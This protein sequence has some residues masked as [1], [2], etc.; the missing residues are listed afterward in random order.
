MNRFF[1]AMMLGLMAC[2]SPEDSIEDEMGPQ[3]SSGD[4]N[5]FPVHGQEPGCQAYAQ[6][7]RLPGGDRVVTVLIPA[8]C[9]PFVFDTGDPPPDEKQIFEEIGNPDPEID[10]EVNQKYL[11]PAM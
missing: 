5:L 2:Q 10:P 11:S 1:L 8:L 7:F 4:L 9:N 6:A 3:D